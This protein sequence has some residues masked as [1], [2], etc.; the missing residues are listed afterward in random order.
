MYARLRGPRGSSIVRR[1]MWRRL[2]P[3]VWTDSAPVGRIRIVR[4]TNDTRINRPSRLS[5]R[6]F[7]LA[8]FGFKI[9]RLRAAV[10]VG[11]A[12]PSN[13]VW[14]TVLYTLA[15]LPAPNDRIGI[16]F[17]DRDYNRRP[18]SYNNIGLAESAEQ[19]SSVVGIAL[20]QTIM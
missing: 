18:C 17:G 9:S 6:I 5:W 19:M 13:C 11:L 4:S 15:E 10:P 16:R 20:H 2:A 14:R 3:P 7:E 12:T 8:V 1:W